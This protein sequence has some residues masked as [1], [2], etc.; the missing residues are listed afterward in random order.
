M[1]WGWIR[2]GF[3]PL[4]AIDHD[5]SALRTHEANFSNTNCCTLHRNMDELKPA[6]LAELL[7]LSPG[8]VSA[9]VGGPPC[10][11]WSRVG[12]GKLRSLGRAGEELLSDP[13]NK[14]YRRFIE[15]VGFFK[16]AVCV[17]ENVP[18]MLSIQKTNIA[19][20]VKSNFEAI[21]YVC[22]FALVNARWFGVP[23]DRNRLIF[24]ATKGE[25]S[26]SAND[27]QAFS[28][29]FRDNIVRL[30]RE[31][32]V[33]DA[34]SDL[35]EIS[36]GAKEDPIIY[37]RHRGSQSRYV[38][39]MREGTNGHITDHVCRNQNAQ[40]V[41]AFASMHEGM[42]YHELDARFK[43][44]RDDIFR[45]KYKRLFWNRVAWT[46]TAHLGKDCYTHI[47]PKQP[48]TISVR[49]AARLQSFPDNFRFWGNIGDRFRQIGNAVP[50]LMAWGI[51]EFMKQ[52]I[53]KGD[54]S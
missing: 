44:Y 41:E 29:T 11:G 16:P 18:G 7:N 49:E 35:P 43:R 3:T 32:T 34:I 24:I 37:R 28:R 54:Q 30:P 10:Q 31:M 48:R 50:P 1:T 45:D 39:I 42:K 20:I 38:E 40:D 36:N 25:P 8:K 6:E 5:S 51:A 2:A 9:I 14:L 33:G 21:G 17:M 53:N 26:F 4:A 12:R 15:M 52:H 23:Q 47:H 22:S 19:S 13:R 27:L 46:V